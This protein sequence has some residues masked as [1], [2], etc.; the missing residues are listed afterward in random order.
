MNAGQD[1]SPI[2]TLTTIADHRGLPAVSRLLI[3]CA[4]CL[5]LWSMRHKSRQVLSE[6]D[7]FQLNDIGLSRSDVEKESIKRFWMP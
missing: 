7:D 3:T 6:L 1:H 4:A 2:A 5:A